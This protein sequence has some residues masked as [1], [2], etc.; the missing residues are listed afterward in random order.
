MGT[1]NIR[2]GS[3]LSFDEEQERDIISA[4][5]ALNASHQTGKFLSN[6]IRIALEN[7]EILDVKDGKYE[8]GVIIKQMDSL[9]MTYGRYQFINSITKE[10]DTMKKKVDDI[11]NMVL[12]VYMLS[13]M[14]K[15]LGLEQKSDNLLSATFILEKQVK[16]LQ[17]TLGIALTSSAFIANKKDDAKKRADD[18]LEYILDTYSDIVSELKARLEVQK[19]EVPIP[20]SLPV[21]NIS[22]AQPQVSAQPIVKPMQPVQPVQPVVNST[23]LQQNSLDSSGDELVDFGNA[24]TD[25]LTDFFGDAL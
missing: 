6:L 10:V 19:I 2:L 12:K 14:G 9:G 18:A 4:I 21:Q 7:P 24:D 15:H 23:V 20:Q 8:K 1:Y 16:E 22:N 5:E 11:Y 17:D 25:L 3:M 13:Q